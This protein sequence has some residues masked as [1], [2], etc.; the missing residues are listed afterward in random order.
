MQDLSLKTEPPWHAEP[1]E[2]ALE[3][4]RSS[5]EGLSAD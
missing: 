1:T 5:T 4:C 3:L 2:A